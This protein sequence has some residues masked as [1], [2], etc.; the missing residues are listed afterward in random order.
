MT[1]YRNVFVINGI[2]MLVKTSFT[3]V[4]VK[5]DVIHY[6]FVYQYEC[7]HVLFNLSIITVQCF[8]LLISLVIE[9]CFVFC[10]S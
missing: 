7:Y 5:S 1:K 8:F 2:Q 4:M 9:T 10:V 6:C 3:T